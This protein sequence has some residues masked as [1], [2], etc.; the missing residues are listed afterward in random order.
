MTPPF[1]AVF[2]ETTQ[3]AAPTCR[4]WPCKVIE[5]RPAV[6]KALIEIPTPGSLF[7]AEKWVEFSD[8]ASTRKNAIAK[9][10]A[11]VVPVIETLPALDEKSAALETAGASAGNLSQ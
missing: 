11:A 1:P 5:V 9:I 4:I 7:R 6:K 2:I 3:G 8:L 10:T